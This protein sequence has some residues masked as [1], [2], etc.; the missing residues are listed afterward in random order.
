MTTIQTGLKKD[1]LPKTVLL[2]KGI[3]RRRYEAGV[4]QIARVS[5]TALQSES[6]QVF[7]L[8]QGRS[9]RLCISQETANI[10]KRRTISVAGPILAATQQLTK[11]RYLRRWSRRLR[12]LSFSRE[13][14]V[15]LAYGNFGVNA[16][17]KLAVAE[18][19]ITTD[20]RLASHFNDKR[21][22][23]EARF[24][25]MTENL[26]EPYSTLELPVVLTA[27]EVLKLV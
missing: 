5:L 1:R 6:A 9:H 10:L 22:E 11:G 4:R 14:G 25:R 3:I 15:I 26:H 27:A 20:L 13:D 19:I 21:V 18:A 24:K 16:D 17:G 12:R 2:D 7:D 23:I 8:L